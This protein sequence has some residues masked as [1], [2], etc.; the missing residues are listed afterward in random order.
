MSTRCHILFEGRR[1]SI[2]T[3]KHHDGYPEEIIPQIRTYWQWNG[4]A[5]V[6]EFTAT[7]FYFCKRQVEDMIKNKYRIDIINRQFIQRGTEIIIH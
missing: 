5:Y 4:G 3:Y 2:L 7:W 1:Q 6:D